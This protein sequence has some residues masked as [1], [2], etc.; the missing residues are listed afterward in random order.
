MERQ[1]AKD[2]EAAGRWDE[3]DAKVDAERDPADDEDAWVTAF[4]FSVWGI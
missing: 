4:P 3:E 1:A 2:E